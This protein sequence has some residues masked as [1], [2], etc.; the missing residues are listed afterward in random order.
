[1]DVFQLADRLLELRKKKEDIEEKSNLLNSKIADVEEK[2]VESMVERDLQNFSQAGARFAFS[3][4]TYINVKKENKEALHKWLRE[5]GHANLIGEAV[6][7][8][9]FKS[10]IVKEVLEDSD[11]LPG[12]LQGIV[13]MHTKTKISV[14]KL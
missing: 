5:N 11:E 2:L 13:S 1:M 7:P 10:F 14:T 8:S 6:H 12:E 9:T 4:Q 3:P